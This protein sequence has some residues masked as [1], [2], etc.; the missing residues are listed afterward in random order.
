MSARAHT[1]PCGRPAREEVRICAPCMRA[2]HPARTIYRPLEFTRD[3]RETIY[4]AAA[5]GDAEGVR[6]L[7]AADRELAA[8][9][10]DE[11]WDALTH[12]CFSNTLKTDG[13]KVTG[14]IEAAR[15]L[16]DAGASPN[17]GYYEHD[18]QPHPLLESALYG[19]AAVA[20]NAELTRLL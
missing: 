9:K 15:A 20:R 1:K 3:M 4:A 11:G 6:Q 10:D 8:R 18:H 13:S 16:L 12:L 7:L 14:F 2:T 17:T 5:A 19:A